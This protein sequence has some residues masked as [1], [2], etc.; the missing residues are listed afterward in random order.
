[1]IDHEGRG[2]EEI[3]A[4]RRYG[5]LGKLNLGQSLLHQLDPAISGALIHRERCVA[6]AEA[7]VTAL[8]A[9]GRGAAEALDEEESETFFRAGE[10]V[11][12]VKWAEDVVG[13][14]AAVEG[15]DEAV[16]TF[17]ADGG[18]NLIFGEGRDVGI[19]LWPWE[20]IVTVFPACIHAGLTGDG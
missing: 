19:Q 6:H 10:I 11:L 4:E 12:R 17:F 16:K 8:L 7:R 15:G 2:V 5:R 1:M 9:I 13:R 18:V 14:D 20:S 3:F